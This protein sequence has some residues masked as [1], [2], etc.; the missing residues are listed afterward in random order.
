MSRN[1]P[2]FISTMKTTTLFLSKS[3]YISQVKQKSKN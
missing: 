2:D 3:G 1:N